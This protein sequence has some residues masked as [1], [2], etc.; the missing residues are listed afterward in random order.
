MNVSDPA[1]LSCAYGAGSDCRLCP[2]GGLCPGGYR[3][4]SRPGYWVASEASDSVVTCA[5]PATE[6]CVGWD[7]AGGGT[8]CGRGY[9]AGSVR[10]GACALRFYDPG[11]GACA[12]CPV[13]SSAWER[14]RG[15]LGLVAGLVVVVSVVAAALFVVVKLAGGTFFGLA[16]RVVTLGVWAVITVQTLAMVARDSSSES[17]PD[18]LRMIYGYVSVLTLEVRV[19][20]C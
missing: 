4:W 6:R 15:L 20:L 2:S 11:T 3:L 13:V 16:R 14:Y 5:Y 8:S 12:S 19:C 17:L 7:A 18:A 1:S 10:C 9:L